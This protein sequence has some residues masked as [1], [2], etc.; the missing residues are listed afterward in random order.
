MKKRKWKSEELGPR[1]V[2]GKYLAPVVDVPN[3]HAVMRE[4]GTVQVAA[5]VLHHWKPLPEPVGGWQLDPEEGV[6]RRRGSGEVAGAQIH[7]RGGREGGDERRA[8]GDGHCGESP[9]R[10]EEGRRGVEEQHRGG[11]RRGA[12]TPDQDRQCQGGGDEPGGL[13]STHEEGAGHHRGRKGCNHQAQPGIGEGAAGE[14]PTGASTTR[15]G[16]VH[17]QTRKEA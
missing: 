15:E 3:G 10:F 17:N 6:G 14:Q 13:E 12:D 7:D 2:K 11:K 8:G 9:R 4:D 5:Y 16:G 1:H